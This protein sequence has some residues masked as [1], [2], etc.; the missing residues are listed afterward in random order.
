ML[1]A[2]GAPEWAIT[3]TG[4]R[5]PA[6]SDKTPPLRQL[7]CK[8][9]VGVRDQHTSAYQQVVPIR[10][11]DARVVH[12]VSGS[13]IDHTARFKGLDE[14]VCGLNLKHEADRAERSV[15][16]NGHGHRRPPSDDLLQQSAEWNR[17]IGLGLLGNRIAS[18][19]PGHRCGRLIAKSGDTTLLG[20]SATIDRDLRTVGRNPLRHSRLRGLASGPGR[21]FHRGYLA[22]ASTTITG[23]VLAALLVSIRIPADAFDRGTDAG[24]SHPGVGQK[25]TNERADSVDLHTGPSSTSMPQHPLAVARLPRPQIRHNAARTASPVWPDVD[26]C[27]P[28]ATSCPVQ[29]RQSGQTDGRTRTGLHAVF[30]TL[31]PARWVNRINNPVIPGGSPPTRA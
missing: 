25:G 13:Q 30:R 29:E 18:P 14:P 16:G 31:Q 27:C 17:P 22:A 19:R 11:G 26:W 6:A 23:I 21:S 24:G 15:A 12:R 10:G 2:G 1:T 9:I 7:Q 20:T 3:N 28:A 8:G 5:K 4:S